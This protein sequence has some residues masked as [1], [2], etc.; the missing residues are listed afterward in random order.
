MTLDVRKIRYF[1]SVFEEGSFSRAAERE[2]IVQPALSTQ[3]KQLETDLCVKLFERSTQGIQPTPAGQHFYRLCKDLLRALEAAG[4]QMRDFG[5]AISGFIRVGIMPS[6]CRGPLATILTKYSDAYPD[7]EIKIV[8]AYSGT[9]ADAVIAGALDFAICNRPASQTGLKLRLLHRDRVILVSGPTK[10]LT[11]WKP[12]RLAEVQD[13]KLVLP[14]SQHSLR[15]LLD[16]HIKAGK[17]KPARVIEMD[18]L[19]ATMRFVQSSD[20]STTL[21]SV[22]IID[23]AKSDSFILNP[24]ASP[25]LSSDMYELHLPERPLSLPAQKLVQMVHDELLRTPSYLKIKH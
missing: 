9:L 14:S 5:G 20:W 2:N 19:G 15:R 4:Q 10:K 18:G 11:P 21:P 12:C 17:I 3:I 13:L 1:V 7:V 16:K 23:D 25:D 8:E 24:I 22:A 6:I